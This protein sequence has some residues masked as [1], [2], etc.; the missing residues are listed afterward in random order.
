MARPARTVPVVDRAGL[1]PE[2]LAAMAAV[3]GE[4]RTLADVLAWGRAQAPPRTVADIVTQDEYT[5]D[6]VVALARDRYLVY[7]TS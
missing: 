3:V 7:D 6:V 5:H 2:E 4:H 1:A